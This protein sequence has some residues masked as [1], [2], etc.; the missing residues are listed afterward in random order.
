VGIQFNAGRAS[1]ATASTSSVFYDQ[2]RES[3]IFAFDRDISVFQG[4]FRFSIV[5]KF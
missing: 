1:P 3:S 4:M 5:R 2:S